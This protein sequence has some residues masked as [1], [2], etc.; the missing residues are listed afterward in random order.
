ML[1]MPYI[2][3]NQYI[4]QLY[5]LTFHCWYFYILIGVFTAY[6]T[7][8]FYKFWNVFVL[9]ALLKGSVQVAIYMVLSVTWN[10]NSNAII[11]CLTI[12]WQFLQNDPLKRKIMSKHG[13]YNRLLILQLTQTNNSDWNTESWYHFVDIF[14]LLYREPFCTDFVIKIDTFGY[15][16]LATFYVKLQIN[17]VPELFGCSHTEY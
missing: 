15:Y 9:T 17:R 10:S 16:L 4:P 14:L 2:G 5:A 13:S 8:S 1:F 11:K 6:W 7:T 3:I 12:K